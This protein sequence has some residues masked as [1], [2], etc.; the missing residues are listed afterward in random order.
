MG[1]CLMPLVADS[2]GKAIYLKHK[3][4]PIHLSFVIPLLQS[5]GFCS[6]RKEGRNWLVERQ[7]RA[8]Q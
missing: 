8:M 4:T 7:R 6:A 5:E 1:A 2:L 3:L